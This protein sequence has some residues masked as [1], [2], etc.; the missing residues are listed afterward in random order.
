MAV[1]LEAYNSKYV[2]VRINNNE[3]YTHY[4]LIASFYGAIQGK[5]T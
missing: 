5:G 2:T 3:S 4:L 1:P